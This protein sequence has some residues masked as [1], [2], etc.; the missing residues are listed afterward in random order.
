VSLWFFLFRSEEENEPQRHREHR[1]K[2]ERGR[3][4]GEEREM[5]DRCTLTIVASYFFQ[6]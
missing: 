1:G 4:R 3:K 5:E 6:E 2:K